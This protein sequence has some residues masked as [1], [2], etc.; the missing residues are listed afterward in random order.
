MGPGVRATREAPGFYPA[1]G[2]RSHVAV[3]PAPALARLDL[4]ER[5]AVRARR[6][7]APVANLPSSIA[8]RDLQERLLGVRAAAAPVSEKAWQVDIRR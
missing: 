5:G 8:M 7:V 3:T 4:P 2:G 1:G 6:V